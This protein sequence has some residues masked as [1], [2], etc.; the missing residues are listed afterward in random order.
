MQPNEI[1]FKQERDFGDLFN[2]TF[3]FIGAEFKRL[4]TAILYFAVPLLL[5]A[6][7]IGVFVGLRQ[8]EAVRSIQT[9]AANYNNPLEIYRDFFSIYTFLNYFIILAATNILTCTI[10]GYIKLY[11]DKGKDNFVLSEVWKEVTRYFFPV[12][13][14]TFLSAIIISI[15]IIFCIIPGIYLGVSLSLFI[16]LIV[17]EGASFGD[18]FNR[19]FKLVKPKFWMTLGALIVI[20]VIVYIISMILSIPAMIM[21]MKPLFS[22]LQEGR[23][24][25][26]DFGISFYIINGISSLLTYIISSIPTVL[27]A[28]LYYSLVET[29]EKPSLI[30]K[31]GQI[32]ADE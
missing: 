13:G 27:V 18:A 16:P 19:S 26:F 8:Q 29:Y 3:A 28:F 1:N 12:L 10:M 22:S 14:A 32:S 11:V 23:D 24:F 6:A 25:N 20:I 30:D 4:G 17:L 5:I 9:G 21:G 31:I 7:I 15:G 2:A